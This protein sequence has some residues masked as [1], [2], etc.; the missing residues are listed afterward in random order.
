MATLAK[1][2]VLVIA[3]LGT[4]QG[5]GASI[6][7]TFVKAGYSVALVA[8]GADSLE[9]FAAEINQSGGEAAPIPVQSYSHEDISSAWARIRE[10][11]PKPNYSIRAAVFNAASTTW[12]AFLDFTHQE[13]Q[14][15]FQSNVAAAFSFSREAILE[16]KRNDIQELTGKRGTLIFT[17]ATASVRGNVTTSAFSA[18][19]HAQRALSQSLAKEFG[20]EN[21]HVAHAI[22]DGGINTG[23]A[24]L[25]GRQDISVKLEPDSIAKAYLYLAE[26]DSSSFTWEL[27]LRP[28]QEKW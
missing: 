3:G 17:G 6:A 11:Y 10:R 25:H 24:S 27:D 15:M 16:F 13:I 21:I 5:T 18:V 1:R 9:K 22:I 12:K 23:H 28:A 19:K 4:G 20:K 2:S 7:R 14:D 26:Q 8:R